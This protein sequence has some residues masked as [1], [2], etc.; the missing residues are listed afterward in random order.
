MLN[1]CYLMN[2]IVFLKNECSHVILTPKSS[3]ILLQLE[4]DALGKVYAMA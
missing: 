4:V 3:Q 1:K 2:I